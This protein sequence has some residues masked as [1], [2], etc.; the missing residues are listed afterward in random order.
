MTTELFIQERKYLKAV[1]DKT[2]AWYK[3]SFKAFEGALDSTETIKVRIMELR[4][5]GVKPVSVNTWLRCVKAYYLWQ[6]KEWKMPW[7]KEEQKILSTLSII[8]IN[9][10]LAYK[11]S[12]KSGNLRRAHLIAL[13][14]LDCG[15][16]ATEVLGMTIEELDVE[17]LT[18]KVKGKGGK[19]RLIPF[20]VELRKAVWRHV[21]T[22][23]GKR[24][25]FGTKHDTQVS[26]R[27]FERDLKL[28]G[29]QLSITGV[30]FSPHTL[31]HSFAIG[32]LRNGG[33][34]YQLSRILGH[35]SITTTTLY[36]KSLGIED[37]SLSHQRFSP[38][39]AR[40]R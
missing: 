36:L 10:L 19:H 27:N 40:G 33:D 37:L 32:W 6:G 3:D 17:N 8:Q 5:R 34:L 20:S 35:S 4:K 23:S 24:F 21:Q 31:R 9:Q 38:L 26:V 28:L 25:V 12:G 11:A 14:I 39:S 1:T 30:R 18:I 29:K 7:Q 13:T 15:L 16:R 2:L 22:K